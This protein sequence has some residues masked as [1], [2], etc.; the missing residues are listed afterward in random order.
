MQGVLNRLPTSES[1]HRRRGAF[2]GFIV[3][4][5]VPLLCLGFLSSRCAATALRSSR[6]SR[7]RSIPTSKPLYRREL[8]FS[9]LVVLYLYP[10]AVRSG[11]A[12]V[13]FERQ[14][15]PC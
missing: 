15:A 10:S 2:A 11:G 13:W 3:G 14:V 1:L 5:A 4:A 6:L 9:A 7:R 12:F 8:G